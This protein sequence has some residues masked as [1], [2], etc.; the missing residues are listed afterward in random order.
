MHVFIL[1]FPLDDALVFERRGEYLPVLKDLNAL[2]HA[3]VAVKTSRRRHLVLLYEVK[4]KVN[5]F[6]LFDRHGLE[7]EDVEA[8]VLAA[9]HCVVEGDESSRLR[10]VRQLAEEEL[11]LFV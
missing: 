8:T 6:E 4:L 9:A 11:T 3:R 2:Y 1:N 5:D 7:A 10:H